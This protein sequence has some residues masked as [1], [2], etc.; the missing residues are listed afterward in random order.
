[1]EANNN[2]SQFEGTPWNNDE[3]I[4][5]FAAELKYDKGHDWETVKSHL[6]SNGLD[7]NYSDAIILNLKDLESKEKSKRRKKKI[8]YYLLNT[9]WIAFAIAV[10]RPFAYGI[11]EIYG[12]IIFIFIVVVGL[13]IVRQYRPS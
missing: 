1:M 8:I 5:A 4:Y 9:L 13:N 6:I 3:E 7:D 10:V 12:K 2:N 11:S